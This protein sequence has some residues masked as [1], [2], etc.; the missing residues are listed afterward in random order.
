MHDFIVPPSP[1]FGTLADI[2]VLLAIEYLPD[3][4]GEGRQIQFALTS[5][6]CLDLAEKLTTLARRVLADESGSGKSPN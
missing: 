2:A 4:N 3:E 6:Q 5:Q 1:R